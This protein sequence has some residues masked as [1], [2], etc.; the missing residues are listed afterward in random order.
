[1]KTIRRAAALAL[2]CLMVL[3]LAA[4]KALPTKSEQFTILVRGNLDEIYLGRAGSD[5]LKLTGTTAED[6]AASYEDSLRQEAT[7]F[8]GYF[9]ITHPTDRT[10]AEVVELYRQIYANASYIVGS[11]AKTDDGTYAVS[12]E[13]QPLNIME[14]ALANPGEAMAT[15]YEK[16]GG[17]NREDLSGEELA[18]FEADW[19]DAVIT[20]V[21]GQLS[22]VTYRDTVTVDVHVTQTEEGFWQMDAGDLQAV[23]ALILCYPAD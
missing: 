17:V 11:A 9:D 12:V 7:F 1:M 2:A 4:C 19:A 22:H 21:R 5:Y 6:V 23:D 8:C 10:M 3:S 20:L 16:H 13:I 14:T 18:E 15:F